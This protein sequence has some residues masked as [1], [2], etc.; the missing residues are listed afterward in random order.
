MRETIQAYFR[1]WIDADASVLRST[2]ADDVV[3]TECYGPEYCGIGQVESWFSDWHGRGKV[4]EWKIARML[5]VGRTVV[6]E[7]HFKCVYDGV[8]DEFDGVTIADFDAD[9]KVARLREFQSKSEHSH[10]YD[11]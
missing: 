8:T 11:N 1:A 2:F 9:N 5:E 3:Y 7:W 4:L 6:A 10:P